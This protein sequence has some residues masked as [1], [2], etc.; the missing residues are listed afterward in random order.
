M[1]YEKNLPTVERVVRFVIGA[2]AVAG[3]IVYFGSAPMG[4]ALGLMGV[5]AAM[6]GVMGFCPGCAMAGRR[7]G[8]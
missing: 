4:W 6:S 8:K 3:G 2:A 1:F 5:M 7:L